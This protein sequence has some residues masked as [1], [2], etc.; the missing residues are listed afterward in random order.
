VRRLTRVERRDLVEELFKGR[1]RP[2]AS[3]V[4]FA[5]AKQPYSAAS[6]N[7]RL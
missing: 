1:P 2:L 5:P 4:G 3:K 7:G 6:S